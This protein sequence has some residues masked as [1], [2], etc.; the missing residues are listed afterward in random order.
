MKCPTTGQAAHT[1]IIA[2]TTAELRKD[3]TRGNLGEIMG[4]GWIDQGFVD[5]E[6]F[7]FS[8]NNLGW[9]ND[10]YSRDF[11]NYAFA[12]EQTF[13]EGKGGISPRVR[14]PRSLPR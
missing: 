8:R 9:D 14:F 10:Y 4:I 12:L 2:E 13:W 7:D 6:T 3:C 5:L 1:R 11:F